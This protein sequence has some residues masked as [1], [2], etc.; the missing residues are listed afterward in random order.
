[1]I[2]RTRARLPEHDVSIRVRVTTF[3]YLFSVGIA[4][5]GAGKSVSIA[6][7]PTPRLPPIRPDWCVARNER[8]DSAFAVA[9]SQ[10]AVEDSMLPLKRDPLGGVQHSRGTM[11]GSDFK[12]LFVLFL[13][14]GGGFWVLAPLARAFAKRIS[15]TAPPVGQAPVLDELREELRQVRQEVAELAERVDFTERAL[16]QQQPPQRL[17]PPS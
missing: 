2:I 5:H 1:M 11:I 12:D 13:V 17:A 9:H 15:A 3:G 8:V 4:C 10:Q 6:S 14:F 16:A 7:A